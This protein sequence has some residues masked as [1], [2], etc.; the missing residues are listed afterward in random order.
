M[1]ITSQEKI[2]RVFDCVLPNDRSEI[3][4]YPFMI[5]FPVRFAGMSQSEVLFDPIKLTQCYDYF[6]EKIGKPDAANM[7]CLGD[8]ALTYPMKASLPGRDLPDDEPYQMLETENMTIEDYKI[9]IKDGWDPWYFG[10]LMSL[11]KPPMTDVNQLFGFFG[12]MGQRMGPLVEYCMKKDILPFVGA[13]VFPAYDMLSMIRSFDKFI[14]DLYDEPDLVKKALEVVTDTQIAATLDQTANSPNK[15]AGLFAMR[16]DCDVSSPE[17]FDEFSFPYLKKEILA[18]H[19]AGLQCVLHC[20]SNWLPILDRFLTLPK[21]SVHFEFDGVTDIFK[22]AQLL[23]GWH[24]FRGDVPA[25]MF[26]YGTADDVS[27]YCE[28]LITEIGMKTPGFMLSSGCEVP[29]NAKPENVKAMM[30]SVKK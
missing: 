19:E 28:K 2:Y 6:I 27:D 10:L 15:R 7:V 26:A 21:H 13:V 9:I 20:D 1:T 4:V 12:E 8:I 25:T 14:F 30:D 11:H 29:I 3:P 22:A 16:S 18:F 23:D 5:T 24:S 17:I